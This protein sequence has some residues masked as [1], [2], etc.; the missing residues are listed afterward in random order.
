MLRLYV[1]E[2]SEIFRQISPSVGWGSGLVLGGLLLWH[3]YRPQLKIQIQLQAIGY[4]Y[5]YRLH[6]QAHIIS[7]WP[8]PKERDP[9][10]TWAGLWRR[11]RCVGF[12]WQPFFL[13]FRVQIYFWQHR[14]APTV[15]GGV[16]V[17]GRK[18]N[19]NGNG[20]RD[21][22]SP[23]RSALLCFVSLCLLCFI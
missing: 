17:E 8:R 12:S 2:F 18:G 23:L 4:R 3:S 11:I 16:F 9:T 14:L 5:S 10:E 19:A 7:R 1:K 22:I 20:S 13:A 6:L 15:A 21:Q